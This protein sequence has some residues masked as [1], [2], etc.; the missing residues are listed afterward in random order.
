LR[1]QKYSVGVNISKKYWFLAGFWQQQPKTQFQK[2]TPAARF[3]LFPHHPR[4][5]EH[6]KIPSAS[7]TQLFFFSLKIKN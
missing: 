4:M 5:L 6:S 2:T 3:I 1:K 7:T